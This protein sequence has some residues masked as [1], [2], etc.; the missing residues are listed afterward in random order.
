MA[1]PGPEGFVERLPEPDGLPDWISGD[2]LDHYIAEF[3]RT[4]FTGG[5]NWYRNLDRNWEIMAHPVSPTITVPALFIAGADDPVLSFM[6]RDRATEVVTGP[7]REVMIDGAGHWLQQ[8]RPDKIN[9]VLL[10]FL[11]SL[12]LR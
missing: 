11:S 2:E 12:E 9:E 10:D 5:L 8:E 6:R 1:R 3:T 4:G 7:Y